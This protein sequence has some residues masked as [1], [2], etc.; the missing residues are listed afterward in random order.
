MVRAKQLNISTLH[1]PPDVGQAGD[2]TQPVVSVARRLYHVERQ[3]ILTTTHGATST[4]RSDEIRTPPV[5]P[6]YLTGF[7]GLDNAP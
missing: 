4:E 7:H 1:L 3:A 6:R 2:A 5:R